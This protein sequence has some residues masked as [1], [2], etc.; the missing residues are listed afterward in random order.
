M[1]EPAPHHAPEWCGAD[2]APGGPDAEPLRQ[3][4]L[5]GLSVL[6]LVLGNAERVGASVTADPQT[7]EG[8]GTVAH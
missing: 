5:A 4:D 1:H 7:R 6:P 2:L 3:A 8:T